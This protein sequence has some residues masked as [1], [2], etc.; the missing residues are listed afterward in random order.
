MLVWFVVFSAC[1]AAA[2]YRLA[3]APP[4]AMFRLLQWCEPRVLY[5]VRTRERLVA[6]TID[7]GPSAEH[8]DE[9]LST[10]EEHGAQATFFVLSR[11]VEEL[12]ELTARITAAGHELGNHLCEDIPAMQ[13]SRR[14]FREA[15][16]ESHQRLSEWGPVRWFRPPCAV[17]SWWMLRTVEQLGYRVAL[18][19]VYPYDALLAS[20]DFSR[21][22]VLWNVRPGSII[23]LHDGPGRGSRTVQVL[24]EVLPALKAEG[25]EILALQS[26]SERCQTAAPRERVRQLSR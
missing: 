3:I 23:V 10:L 25:Y 24:R 22:F 20:P 19:S 12:P 16:A 21:R 5:C 2:L 13:M 9:I 11:R 26:L 15:L 17:Y 14:R 18:G 8:C 6:L 1:G 4:V 7:D